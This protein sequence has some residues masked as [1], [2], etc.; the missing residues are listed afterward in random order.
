MNALSHR[1][2]DFSLPLVTFSTI[3]E[4]DRLSDIWRHSQI[5]IAEDIRFIKQYREVL[6]QRDELINGKWRRHSSAYVA[7]CETNLATTLKRYAARVR[8]IT[9]TEMQMTEDGIRFAKSSDAWPEEIA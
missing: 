4:A 5:G 6:S 1:F 2:A 9:E 8:K 3:S 7:A